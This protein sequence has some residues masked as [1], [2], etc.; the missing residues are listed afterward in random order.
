MRSLLLLP[1]TAI[2]VGFVIATGNGADAADAA[3]GEHAFAKCAPC[4]AKDTTNGIG[5]GL[6]GVIGRHAG[7]VPGFRYSRAM[8][9]SGIVWDEKSLDAFITQPQK[10]LPGTTMP[11]SGIPGQEERKDLIA[12]LEMLK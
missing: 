1:I 8:K 12:Y 3:H 7:S 2:A 10:I 6:L 9:N 11:F 4:H 5:P